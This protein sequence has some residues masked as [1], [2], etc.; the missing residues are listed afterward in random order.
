MLM[1]KLKDLLT[2]APKATQYGYT[3]YRKKIVSGLKARG[4]EHKLKYAPMSK[5][6]FDMRDMSSGGRGMKTYNLKDLL[7]AL[8]SYG[9]KASDIYMDDVDLVY[10][11]KTIDKW[12]GKSYWWLIS[13]LQ[14]K[15]IIRKY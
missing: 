15:K 14:K 13:L 8:G 11:D 1:I 3:T 10:V 2:E 7:Q 6:T 12:K 4:N 9:F 5:Q